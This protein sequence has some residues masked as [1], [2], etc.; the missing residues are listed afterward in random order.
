M[1]TIDPIAVNKL[2]DK[3]FNE[4]KDKMNNFDG[5]NFKKIIKEQQNANDKV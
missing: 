1:P 3:Y 4:A 5:E 2:V